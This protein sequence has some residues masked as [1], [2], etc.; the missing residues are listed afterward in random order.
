MGSK[1][2]FTKVKQDA[3]AV[4]EQIPVPN[5]KPS[6]PQTT[7]EMHGSAPKKAGRPQ[8]GPNYHYTRIAI[9]ADVWLKMGYTKVETGENFTDQINNALRQ[10]L[11]LKR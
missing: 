8:K 6:V 11:G 2:D 3:M 5:L 7:T 9:E 1:I 10:Y 4:A